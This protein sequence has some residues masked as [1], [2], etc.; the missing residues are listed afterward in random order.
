M[1]D[2]DRTSL[3]MATASATGLALRRVVAVPK[4]TVPKTTSGKLRR[5]ECRARFLAG[6][7]DRLSPV[8]D[9][10]DA[11]AGGDAVLAA[12]RAVL[13]TE[14]GPDDPLVAHGL[15][16]LRAVRLAELLLRGTGADVGVRTLLRGATV[17]DLRAA[18]TVAHAPAGPA[19]AM[20]DRLSRAQESLLFLHMLDPTSD[21][22][23]IS[24]AWEPVQDTDLAVL[25]EAIRQALSWRPE[26]AT[27]IVPNG[28]GWA[29]GSIGDRALRDALALPPIPVP[30]GRLD[31]QVRAAAAMPFELGAGPLVRL[32]RWQ[33]P[34]GAVYQ[35][36][37]HHLV[38]DLWSLCLVLRDI[39][40]C[41]DALRAGR[42]PVAPAAQSYSDYVREQE[43][44]LA[45]PAAAARDE[46]LRALLPTRAASVDVRTDRPRPAR[47]AGRA[48]Q[49]AVD[50]AGPS[51][52]DPVAALVVA[53][54]I[55]LYRYGTPSPVVVGVPVSGR[56]TGRHTTEAGL[57]TNTVP[58]ALDIG[59]DRDL[60]TLVAAARDQLDRGMDAGF[61]PLARAV[62]VVRPD[63]TAG[64][65]PLVET[66]VTV[67]ENPLPDVPGLLDSLAGEP[68]EIILGSLALRMVP[69][70]GR[71][72]RYDLDLVITPH[73]DGHRVRLDYAA[74]LFTRATAE[75][76]LATF[77][78]TAGAAL[79]PGAA[80][81]DL[82][83]LSGRD[84]GML[85]VAGRCDTAPL[86]PPALARIRRVAA[87][88]PDRVAVAG[89]DGVLTYQRFADRM[90]RVAAAVSAVATPAAGWRQAALLLPSIPDFAVAVFGAWAA[91]LGI[92]PL[93]SDHPDSRLSAMISD[94]PTAVVL[95]TAAAVERARGL[96]GDLP[97]L[98]VED[99]PVPEVE[100]SGEPPADG[101]AFTVYTSG[102]ANVLLSAGDHDRA[103]YHRQQALAR[104]TTLGAPQPSEPG[105]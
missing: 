57:C 16:S 71:A 104:Y 87:V 100:P 37:V 14:P 81:E 15:D 33:P 2:T 44:Y 102:L 35:L 3:A 93:P 28:Q 46:E 103:H 13:G 23:T 8:A 39:G 6:D 72:C 92:L 38:T 32:Y 59:R 47:R 85:A 70:P 41:Y 98:V 91:G 20:G 9:A 19:A 83:A 80:P 7:Y 97:V 105:S 21:E 30:D 62:E 55:T 27:R 84:R 73:A 95:T 82:W 40:T 75:S 63:R 24:F 45:G 60:A 36:V 25:D 77:A 49:V 18:A 22:Y 54:A 52:R 86:T 99:L 74:D 26:L 96:A 67:H 64:R 88:D 1:T 69:V 76:L 58:I 43:D 79:D 10:P 94:G 50:L 48:G 78:A 66:L 56:T 17:A 12:V 34:T 101:P 61:Y 5:A 53:W 42:R 11:P 29:R 90:D 65:H 31:D 51:A 68:A 89:P 4:G